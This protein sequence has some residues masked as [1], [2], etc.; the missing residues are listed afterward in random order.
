[1]SERPWKQF[2]MDMLDSVHKATTYIAGQSY[3]DFLA[4]TKTQDAVVRN[5]EILGEAARRIPLHIQQSRP[6]IPWRQIAGLR[7]R[8]AHGY[9]A[10]DYAIVWDIVANELPLL[11]RNWKSCC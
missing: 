11:D 8:L 6:E 3:S 5:L 10:I 9:F 7:N 4:D 1:M 2:L